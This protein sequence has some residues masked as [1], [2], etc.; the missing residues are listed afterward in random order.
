MADD[1]LFES[2]DGITTETLSEAF[3]RAGISDYIERGLAVTADYGNAV[4]DISSGKA[5]V[6]HNGRDLTVKPDARAGVPLATDGTNYIYLSITE[7]TNS[8]GSTTLGVE[9]AVQQGETAPAGTALL[10]AEVD[11]AAQNVTPR[12]DTAPIA[13]KDATSYKGNDID[14]DGDGSVDRADSA[15]AADALAAG[16]TVDGSQVSGQ[17]PAAAVADAI[18][19]AEYGDLAAGDLV[20]TGGALGQTRITIGT[21][22]DLLIQDAQNAADTF[23]WR[24]SAAGRLWLGGNN[25]TPYLR[26]TLVGDGN[27]IVGVNDVRSQT[28]QLSSSGDD[29]L[30]LVPGEANDPPQPAIVP[31]ADGTAKYDMALSYTL[32]NNHWTVQSGL[33]VADNTTLVG[34]TQIGGGEGFVIVPSPSSNPPAIIPRSGGT[35][36]E[37]ERLTFDPADGIWEF[38]GPV[39]IGGRLAV[40]GQRMTLP[41]VTSDPGAAIN[42]DMWF[43]T[44]KQ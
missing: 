43:R 36:F 41:K 19:S 20:H 11:M 27:N 39:A 30:L 34:E 29:G 4:A 12:N 2:G 28:V 18:V 10:I 15:A 26:T 22:S 16:A 7:S 24:D 1:I 21:N 32:Y 5:F 31:Y 25:A 13:S 42:G 33:K 14:T 9:Y 38:G 6:L 35:R 40:N 23:I 44:D 37:A 17:V 8:D 3:G